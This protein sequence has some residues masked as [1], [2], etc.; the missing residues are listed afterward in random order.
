M[1][2]LARHLAASGEFTPA[3]VLGRDDRAEYPAAACRVLDGWGLPQWYVPQAHGGRFTS[4]EEL[5]RFNTE[6]SRADMTVAAA[7]FITF[8]A[9]AAVWLAGEQQQAAR[10]ADR[11]LAGTTLAWGISERAHGG[12]L[13]SGEATAT[14]RQGRYRLDGEKWPINNATRSDMVIMLAR[15]SARPGIYAFDLIIVDKHALDPATYDHLPR[16]PTHGIRGL[17]LSGIV[18]RGAEVPESARIGP[19]GSGMPTL[20]K[21]LTI[22]RTMCCGFATGTGEQA[23]R[24]AAR[25]R[26]AARQ[27]LSDAY[28][29][30]L[31]AQALTLAAARMLQTQPDEAAL[32]SAIAKY[33][34]P[35]WIDDAVSALTAALGAAA[36][37]H[38]RKAARDSA[39]VGIFDGNTVTNL[40]A[41]INH[42]PTLTRPCPDRAPLDL[43]RPPPAPRLADLTPLSRNGLSLLARLPETVRRLPPGPLA[44]AAQLLHEQASDELARLPGVRRHPAAAHFHSAAR[45]AHCALAA[46][47]LEIWQAT[48]AAPTE[49]LWD[50]GQW[51]L[52]VVRRALARLGLRPPADPALDGALLDDLL[53]KA[54][55]D[56]PLTVLP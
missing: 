21:T 24:L 12:D 3:A 41:I 49:P 17:D 32:I 35:T 36:D 18:F 1:T 10:L 56:R 40:Q 11:I 25:Q 47:A 15:T 44:Q 45:L 39:I 6:V 27:I 33:T 5:I 4:Y 20:L 29:D 43:H 14:L 2:G 37:P 28:A 19:S 31:G 48:A 52:A 51:P 26:P 9:A 22:T 42:F 53:S 54:R 16:T 38:F 55:A 46:S 34:V 13:L 23:L 7:H 30:L 8:G 50:G